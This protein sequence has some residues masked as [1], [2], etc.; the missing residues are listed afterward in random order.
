MNRGDTAPDI[1]LKDQGGNEIRLSEA[2]AGGGLVVFFYPKDGT[3]VCAKEAC[4]FRDNYGE[5]L[6]YNVKVVGV[7]SD[8][9][10]SHKRFAQEHNLAFPLLWD[11]GGRLRKLWKVPGTLGVLP[12]RVTYILDAGMVVQSV[13]SSQLEAGKHVTTALEAVRKM[14]AMKG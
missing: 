12:G 13:F 8:D 10:T 7:S 4:A 6:K 1:V 11:E 2:A 5:F 9:S 14:D 3:P